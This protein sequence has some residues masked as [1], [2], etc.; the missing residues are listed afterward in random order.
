MIIEKFVH[1]CLRLTLDGEKLLIDPGKFGFLDGRVKPNTL[2]DV[3]GVFITHSYPDDLDLDALRVI[4]RGRRARVFGNA[5]LAAGLEKAGIDVEVVDGAR[6]RCGPFS[7]QAI[8][9]RHEPILADRLP[10]MTAVLV[11]DQLLHCGN[12]FDEALLAHAG[13]EVLA[14]PVMAP[15][16]T[17]LRVM[18]FALKMK[19]RHVIPVHDG[20]VYDWFITQRYDV[21]APYF[22]QAGINFVQMKT[23]G[24][25]FEL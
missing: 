7:L 24:A 14:L 8:P 23:P 10:S 1:S 22:E 12:S 16:L 11:N 17:E 21:Y 13:V 4:I 20:Q 3:C 5:E 9:V 19:P 25:R 18:D 6:T 15:F 2:N